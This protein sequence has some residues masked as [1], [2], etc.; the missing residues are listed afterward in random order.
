M[1]IAGVVGAFLVSL[2]LVPAAHAQANKAKRHIRAGA[3]QIEPGTDLAAFKKNVEELET[4]R[5]L[6][7]STAKEIESLFKTLDTD[8]DGKITCDDVSE[9][10]C[11]R[12]TEA[13]KKRKKPKKGGGGSGPTTSGCAY[14]TCGC[15]IQEP[16]VDLP[17]GGGGNSGGEGTTT[18]DSGDRNSSQWCGAGCHC[19]CNSRLCAK[20]G[21]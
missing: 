21:T 13:Y 5:K 18:S 2:L 12:D 3:L 10:D 9:G 6:K 17:S 8:A 14:N 19:H 20:D 1:K 7:P 4:R 11:G 16:S 15:D